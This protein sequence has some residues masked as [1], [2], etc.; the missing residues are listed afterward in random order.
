MNRSLLL[1]ATVLLLAGVGAAEP[2]VPAL[3]GVV[4]PDTRLLVVAPHP[5]DEA[6]GTG[7]LIQRVL[8]HRGAVRVIVITSGDGFPPGV[9]LEMHNAHP[10]PDDYRAYA[11]LRERET[12]RSLGVLGVTRNDIDF[13]GFPDRGL[14]PM[15]EQYRFDRPPYYRSPFTAADRPPVAEATLPGLP[16]LD[17][18]CPHCG[19]APGSW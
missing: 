8:R 14:C 16:K 15:L 18:P 5:D 4:T 6:L 13:L 2:D 10:R 9:V 7:G 1:A 3:E 12:I 17:A 11:R 19:S